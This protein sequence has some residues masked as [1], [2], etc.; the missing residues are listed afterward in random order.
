MYVKNLSMPFAHALT[1]FTTY[2]TAEIALSRTS[3]LEPLDLHV[4]TCYSAPNRPNILRA[5]M[6]TNVS[7]HFSGSWTRGLHLIVLTTSRKSFLWSGQV[8]NE[9]V[10][11]WTP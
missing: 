9:L 10:A 11:T 1:H 5:Q 2:I 3:S 8:A 4:P 7:V 6:V